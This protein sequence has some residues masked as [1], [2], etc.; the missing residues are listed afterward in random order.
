LQS[1]NNSATFAFKLLYIFET[2]VKHTTEAL[3]HLSVPKCSNANE[4]K[5][6]PII[7]TIQR[8]SLSSKI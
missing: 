2:R 6:S 4:K 3:K 8:K 5:N 1:S 7:P